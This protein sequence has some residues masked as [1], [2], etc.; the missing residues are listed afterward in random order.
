MPLE[1]RRLVV[2]AERLR[3]C[4]VAMQRQCRATARARRLREEHQR[5]L[6]V[7]GG[8]P[9]PIPCRQRY[10][11][12]TITLPW[13]TKRALSKDFN[14]RANVAKAFTQA[15]GGQFSAD[16]IRILNLLCR[17]SSPRV[18]A[19]VSAALRNVARRNP[20]FAV[21]ARKLQEQ[22]EFIKPDA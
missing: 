15:L 1:Q 2:R 7:F 9:K 14:I 4:C 10:T 3:L 19:A 12:P 18:R 20:T 8:Q 11:Y 6:R 5:R 22:L 21:Q 17:D 13:L 16:A